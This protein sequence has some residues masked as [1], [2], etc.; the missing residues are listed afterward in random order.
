AFPQQDAAEVGVAVEA[1]AEHVEDLA[2]GPFRARPQIGDGGQVQGGVGLDAGG[3]QRRVQVDLHEQAA[4][5]L[6]ADEVV[7]HGEPA[8]GGAV[9]RQRP[10]GGVVEVVDARHVGKE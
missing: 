8:T 5:V 6:H 1:D 2:F 7:H 3:I 10:L 4:V 9:G